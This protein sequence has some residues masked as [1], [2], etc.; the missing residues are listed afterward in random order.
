MHKISSICDFYEKPDELQ[1]ISKNGKTWTRLE[2]PNAPK[3]P[4]SAYV[5]F[6]SSARAKYGKARIGSAND[7]QTINRALAGEWQQLSEADKQVGRLRDDDIRDVCATPRF[8][9]KKAIPDNCFFFDFPLRSILRK[10]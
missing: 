3:K 6:L 2:D 8:V 10:S 1:E 7:Q 4:R 9:P 5:H